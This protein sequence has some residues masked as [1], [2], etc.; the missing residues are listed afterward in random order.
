MQSEGRGRQKKTCLRS[1]ENKMCGLLLLRDQFFFASR[2]SSWEAGAMAHSKSGWK[3]SPHYFIHMSCNLQRG[4]AHLRSTVWKPEAQVLFL[5]FISWSAVHLQQSTFQSTNSPLLIMSYFF[6][7]ISKGEYKSTFKTKAAVP[8]HTAHPHHAA[9]QSPVAW[10]NFTRQR[11][12][13]H[14]NWCQFALH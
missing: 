10:G 2:D 9:L 11:Q 7:L 1:W 6:R 12:Y 8:L 14:L 3:F 5:F 13:S 4:S